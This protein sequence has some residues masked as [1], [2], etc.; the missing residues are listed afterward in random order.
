MCRLFGFRSVIKSQVHKSL[1]D[2]EN[3]LQTQGHANPDGWGVAYYLG[4]CPHIVKSKETA[5]D[6]HIFRKVSGIVSS[7]T[8]VAHIRLAT[9]GKNCL[10]NTHPFQFGS[11]VFAHNGNIKNFTQFSEEIRSLIN[12]KLAKFILGTTDSEV[13]F[14]FLLSQLDE[15]LQK[16]GE[17]L[18][19][20]RSSIFELQTWIKQAI[21]KL[22][23]IIGS[24]S[25]DN[26]ASNDETFL[27]FLLTNGPTLLAFQ[28]GKS[29]YYSTYKTRCTDRLTCSHFSPECEAPT[30]SGKVN[31]FIISSEKLG[32]ENTWLS[33]K[34]G[35]MVG[36]DEKMLLSSLQL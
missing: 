19:S 2:A 26:N 9:K 5:V 22:I 36:V 6:N 15:N 29:F 27:T 18:F 10:L 31:H 34:P 17:D 14:Y 3:A 20:Y 24:Y 12:P 7:Q 4:G 16:K 35:E 1:I 32:D 23:S 28:G 33:L 30:K 25:Q 21:E 11:W 8:V 13:I